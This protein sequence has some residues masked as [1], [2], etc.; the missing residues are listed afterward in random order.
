MEGDSLML[1]ALFGCAL[2]FPCFLLGWVVRGYRRAPMVGPEE[3]Q[4]Q[5]VEAAA[6]PAKSEKSTTTT[7]TIATRRGAT[8]TTT[9]FPK[10][11]MTRP[12]GG[13]YHLPTC[14]HAKASNATKWEACGV[15]CV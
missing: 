10:V 6:K 11:V 7:T 4:H 13:S 8:T 5:E 9:A 14:V 1:L 15:C 2:S 3:E 12:K